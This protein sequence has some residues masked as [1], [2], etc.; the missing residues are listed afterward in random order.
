MY[1]IYHNFTYLFVTQQRN[2]CKRLFDLF[3]NGPVSL[4]NFLG[5][6]HLLFPNSYS[7][8]KKISTNIFSKMN[9]RNKQFNGLCI[10]FHLLNQICIILY[11]SSTTNC[12][13]SRNNIKY[14]PA[15]FECLLYNRFHGCEILII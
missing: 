15:I 1:L 10:S 5:I 4:F 9:R 3:P 11:F 14:V 8:L 2:I 7:T 13:N 12:S 6:P